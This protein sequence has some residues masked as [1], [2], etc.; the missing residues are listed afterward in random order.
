L[1]SFGLSAGVLTLFFLALRRPSDLNATVA[2]H[3]E[4]TRPAHPPAT[5]LPR[6]EGSLRRM[7]PATAASD[8]VSIVDP[9][10]AAR[11][12]GYRVIAELQSVQRFDEA[13]QYAMTG[14][15]TFRRDWLIAAYH[16]WARVEPETAFVSATAMS[17]E[18]VREIAFQ[19]VLSGWARN[20]PES[21]AALAIERP[22]GPEKSAALT[23]ALRAWAIKDPEKAGNWIAAHESS[24][25][26][27][28]KMFRDE[29]R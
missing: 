22:D 21:L 12:A 20:D 16:E 11:D 28:E 17:N 5:A 24:I 18:A 14:P 23:K 8:P 25:P 1:L 27:A 6:R 3:V 26:I 10:L 7:R 19:S 13:A 29:R 9:S 4:T 2:A 15:D